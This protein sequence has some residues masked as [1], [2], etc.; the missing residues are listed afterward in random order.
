MVPPRLS[1]LHFMLNRQAR[2]ENSAPVVASLGGLGLRWPGEGFSRA[3]GRRVFSLLAFLVHFFF[4]LPTGRTVTIDSDHD[5][6][7]LS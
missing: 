4:L 6:L 1:L 7:P 5:G 2:R 3:K